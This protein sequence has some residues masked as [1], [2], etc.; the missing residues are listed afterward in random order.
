MKDAER[1]YQ[2]S[3]NFIWRKMPKELQTSMLMKRAYEMANQELGPG[4]GR[5]WVDAPNDKTLS[6]DG[7]GHVGRETEAED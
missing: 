4:A 3:L 1:D 5:L 7:D 6:P 2:P